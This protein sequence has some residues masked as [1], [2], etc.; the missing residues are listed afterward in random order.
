MYLRFVFAQAHRVTRRRPG[1]LRDARVLG[2]DSGEILAITGWLNRNLPV[3]PEPA[4]SADRALCWFKTDAR[5]CIEQMRMLALL[6]EREGERIWQIYSRNPGR[7]T[8]EDDYQVVAVPDS[9]LGVRPA[10]AP[11]RR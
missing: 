9:A 8:Y 4:F 7:I 6:L 11:F 10:S 5:A 3:P 2:R 1:L